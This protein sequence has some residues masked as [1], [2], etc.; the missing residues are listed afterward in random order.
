MKRPDI[1]CVIVAF[2]RPEAL[3]PLLDGLDDE[4]IECIVVNVENDP[5]VWSVATSVGALVVPL[6]GNPGYAVAV[7]CG[8]RVASAEVIV[9]LN[10]D[11][12]A[13]SLTIRGLADVVRGG[14]AD[15]VVPR[16]TTR[17]GQTEL[18][19]SAL[20][21][22]AALALEWM[23]LP[24]RPVPGLRRVLRVQKWRQPI[25]REDVPAAAATV[26]ACRRSLLADV[27]LPEGYFLYWEE[28]EWFWALSR[29]AARVVYEPSLV[30]RH[31]GG[32]G[33]VRP[34]KSRLLARNAVRCVRRT[35]GR[36]AALAAWM[37]VVVWNTRLVIVDTIRSVGRP[38]AHAVAAARRGGLRAALRAV[39][40][41]R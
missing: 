39:L 6:V 36:F 4:R 3:A 30:V 18:S 26:V 33:D 40:E 1:A 11:V 5:A 17:D 23:A 20:P 10:D 7:N 34:E 15:V 28:A 21:S 19:I 22:P 35:Q 38:E 37:V 27:P 32:R 41:L 25:G 2:H 14:E 8:A 16:L 31:H 13:D 24:D 29:R 12:V 9:F